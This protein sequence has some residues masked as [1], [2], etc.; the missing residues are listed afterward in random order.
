MTT[1]TKINEDA[2]MKAL[3]MRWGGKTVR[4]IRLI[5]LTHEDTIE[6]ARESHLKNVVD[7]DRRKIRH[8]VFRFNDRTVKYLNR[9]IKKNKVITRKYKDGLLYYIKSRKWHIEN[10][11]VVFDD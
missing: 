2:V 5:G 3:E 8:S 6:V 1:Y 4:E 10:N 11:K 7:Y 9:L